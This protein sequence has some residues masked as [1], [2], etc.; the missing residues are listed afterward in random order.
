MGQKQFT[1]LFRVV[2]IIIF[3]YMSNDSFAKIDKFDL[4][5][6]KIGGALR[7]NVFYKDW[8]HSKRTD[9][10]TIRV[11]ADYEWK[12]L[13]GSVEYRYYYYQDIKEDTHF[14]HHAWVGY[15]FTDEDQIHLGVHQVP[16]GIIPYAS[17]NWF[18]Q[19]PYYVGLE[20][21]YD[22]GLKYIHQH[23]NWNFQFAYYPEDEGHYFGNSN[24][25]ARYSYDVV[26][27]GLDRNEEKNQFNLR[28]AY[29]WEYSEGHQTELGTSFQFG[30]V[31]NRTINDNGFQYAVGLHATHTWNRWN[32]M[33][34]IIR[35]EYSLENPI[36]ISDDY[37][38]MGAYD[39]PYRVASQAN[40][41]TIGASYTIPLETPM[42]DSITFYDDFSYLDKDKRSF[43]DS[44]QNVIGSSL[45]AGNFFIYFDVASG[46]NHPWLGPVWTDA[47]Y[48]GGDDNWHT[49]FNINIGFYI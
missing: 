30:Q 11:N 33:A 9:L 24:D 32:I 41:Y 49:R 46:R 18:F 28:Y 16:F 31:H 23:E 8:S 38:L 29:T 20:D 45:S 19:L 21:D 40:V 48:L 10:D 42:F 44:W 6:I 14:I 15:Q 37:V 25:S 3:Y 2:F 47:F 26:V 5:P 22:L 7:S 35:Y 34:E 27:E 39:F 1:Y 36:G 17:H 13:T 43:L 12:N 4:G